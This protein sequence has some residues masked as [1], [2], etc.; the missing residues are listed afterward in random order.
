MIESKINYKCPICGQT[1]LSKE[2][3]ENLIKECLEK[4][5][6]AVLEGKKDLKLLENINVGNY[7]IGKVTVYNKIFKNHK[8]VIRKPKKEKKVTNPIIRVTTDEESKIVEAYDKGK[9]VREIFDTQLLGDRT[10]SKA[11]IFSILRRKSLLY[12]NRNNTEEKTIL[13]DSLINDMEMGLTTKE[14]ASKN[15]ISLSSVRNYLNEGGLD[16]SQGKEDQE[17]IVIYNSYINYVGKNAKEIVGKQFN[18]SKTSVLRIANEVIEKY[19][20]DK[21]DN[22]NSYRIYTLNQDFFKIIDTE[23]KAYVLGLIATDGC[24]YGNTVTIELKRSD[25]EI[26]EKVSILINSNKPIMNSL[27]LDKRTGLYHEGAKITFISDKLVDDLKQY[28][29]GPKK[30]LTLQINLSSIPKQFH[31]DFWRGSLDGDGAIYKFP[32]ISLVGTEDFCKQFANYNKL[33]LGIELRV[34]LHKQM[35]YATSRRQ[36]NALQMGKHFYE[37]SSILMKTHRF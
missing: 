29:I 21:R 12:K 26:L 25:K 5:P 20:L 23:G 7:T 33:E 14:I 22:S 35:W 34:Y 13:I 6:A 11:T 36:E 27:H 2:D 4:L 3:E 16:I 32:L 31:K 10:P 17:K 18:L 19:K 24:V 15:S 9:E 30:S 37:N 8:I 1:A 28:N